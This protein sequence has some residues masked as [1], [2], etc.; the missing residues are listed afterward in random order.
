[1]ITLRL[2]QGSQGDGTRLELLPIVD[3]AV[4]E[5]IAGS[6]ERD[7]RRQSQRYLCADLFKQCSS[8]GQSIN[9]R[10]G[11]APIAVATEAVGS[12]SINRN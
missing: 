3:N 9:V 5:R 10:R 8:L 4:A 6:E 2:E 11:P 7:V 1:L 12:E